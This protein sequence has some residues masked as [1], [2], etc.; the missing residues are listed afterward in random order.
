MAASSA[1]S[2]VEAVVIGAGV[3]GLAV[4]RALSVAGRREV[5]LIDRADRIGSETSSRNSEVVHAGLYYPRDSFKTKFCVRGRQLLYE[6]CES[7]GVEYRR[8][9]KL[10]VATNPGQSKRLEALHKQAIDNGVS[11]VQLISADAVQNMEPDTKALGGALWSPSTGIVD[12]HAFMVSLLADAEEN[13]STLALHSSVEDSEI[14]EREQRINLLVAGMWLDCKMVVNC[15]GL[16]ADEL[17]RRIHSRHSWHPPSQYFCKGNYFRLQGQRAPFTHLIYPLPDDRGGLGVHA[18]IDVAGQVK[19]GPDV[20]WL[21]PETTPDSI[22]WTPDAGRADAFYS[23]IRQYWPDVRDG[24]LVPD[25]SGVRPKLH[26]PSQLKHNTPIPFYDFQ[27][28]GFSAHGVPGLVHLFGI[29][30]P[31][32]T[33]AMALAEYIVQHELSDTS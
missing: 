16:W 26:H 33:S 9:G 1:A 31:G 18:T 12:S 4:A 23:S 20:Q 17:A 25:Y 15:A 27:I 32:L 19:F 22:D 28:A 29:E 14:V 2:K 24:G 13:G 3:V 10:V 8:C 6:F 11:D 30:S 21:D 5:L 7:R